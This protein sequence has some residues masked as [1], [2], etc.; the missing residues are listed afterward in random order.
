MSGDPIRGET[1]VVYGASGYT[2]K[3]VATKLI[4]SG[5]RVVLAGRDAVKLAKLEVELA[6]K[7]SRDEVVSHAV[8]I[9]DGAGL[10][11]MCGRAAVVI[12]CAGPFSAT[13]RP[14]AAAAV[15]TGAHYLD[16][17]AEQ[18]S[19]LS[20]CED[21]DRDAR[22]R[23]VVVIPACAFFVAIANALA[24]LASRGVGRVEEIEIAYFIAEWRPPA[25]SFRSRI[26]GLQGDWYVHDG[27]LRKGGAWP[28]ATRFDFP[29]PVGRQRMATYPTADV[30]LI[31]RHLAARRVSSSLSARTLAPEAMGPLLPLFA[32]AARSI[33]RTPARR[34]VEHSFDR[35]WRPRRAGREM[36]S[37]PTTF[38]VAASAQGP[39]GARRMHASGVGIY[40]VSAHI[41][42]DAAVHLMDGEPSR[43]GVLAPAQAFDPE[44]LLERLAPVGVRY[45]DYGEAAP[46]AGSPLPPRESRF[47]L[48]GSG[49][50][51]DHV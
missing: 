31:P 45:G 32:N 16:V 36:L 15:A 23:G 14:L 30:V 35:L 41:V 2:G 50:G 34:L 51:H 19:A 21:T 26:E 38:V 13:A 42:A 40:D 24:S 25:G 12:N 9:D 17:S 10:E 46:E 8:S 6:T 5:K 27:A 20:L 28:R 44:S 4:A 29:A 22:K 43:A 3:R 33:L 47:E 39:H 48:K 18:G 1:V 11:V 49:W 37:D 7:G